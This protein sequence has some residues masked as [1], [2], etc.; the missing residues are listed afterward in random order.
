MISLL[1]LL[2][3]WPEIVLPD[4]SLS[5]KFRAQVEAEPYKLEYRAY[6]E[7]R[8]KFQVLVNFH[9]FQRLRAG[10]SYVLLGFENSG[11]SQPVLW[12]NLLRAHFFGPSRSTST[13]SVVVVDSIV[14]VVVEAVVVVER[15]AA[16]IL[17][18][19]RFNCPGAFSKKSSCQIF[20]MFLTTKHFNS[21]RKFVLVVFSFVDNFLANFILTQRSSKTTPT[22]V[23]LLDCF[24]TNSGGKIDKFS[25]K[26]RLRFNS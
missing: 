17:P 20:S 7:P 9:S 14:V 26:A 12:A 13:T 10:P 24:L 22:P 18:C 1:I 8:L 3:F 15:D 11:L 6:F 23:K 21:V 16:V 5:W 4:P 2:L 25:P 19:S